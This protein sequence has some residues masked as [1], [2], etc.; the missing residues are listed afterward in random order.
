MLT[1]S[2]YTW[3]VEGLEKVE[4]LSTAQR[5]ELRLEFIQATDPKCFD[6]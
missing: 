5:V 6:D 4:Y 1:C 2:E 3:L